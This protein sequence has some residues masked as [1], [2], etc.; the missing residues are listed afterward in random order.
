MTTNLYSPNA[1]FKAKI[2]MSP[3]YRGLMTAQELIRSVWF[4]SLG[5]KQVL[6]SSFQN[7]MTRST[8][9]RDWTSS[10]RLTESRKDSIKTFKNLM[11]QK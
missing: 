3:T 8:S 5:R 4:Q 7:E 9:S 2:R 11:I 10:K 1:S 6:E